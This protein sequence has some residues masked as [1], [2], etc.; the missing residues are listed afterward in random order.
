MPVKFGKY[1]IV[2]SKIQSKYPLAP[3]NYDL[4]VLHKSVDRLAEILENN[5]KWV[6]SGGLS[7]PLS[8]GINFYRKHRDIDIGLPRE[9]LPEILGEAEKEGYALFSRLAMAKISPTRKIDLYKQ[10][11]AEEAVESYKSA[12]PD[13]VDRGMKNIRLVMTDVEGKIISSGDILDYFDI[14][15]CSIA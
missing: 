9:A 14:Y 2:I 12:S 15:F 3:A 1:Q 7:I 13:D 10:V 4:F 5:N 8:L 11:S 6:L